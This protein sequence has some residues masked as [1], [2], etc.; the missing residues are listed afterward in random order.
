MIMM[1]VTGA[2]NDA[3]NEFVFTPLFPNA[4]PL[5]QTKHKIFEK[6]EIPTRSYNHIRRIL[7]S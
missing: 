3:L 7:Q 1:V 6:L 2:A 4:S 5:L